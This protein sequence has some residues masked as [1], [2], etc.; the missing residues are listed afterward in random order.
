MDQ[1]IQVQIQCLTWFFLL[2]FG[3][4]RTVDHSCGAAK[5]LITCLMLITAFLHIWSKGHCEPRNKVGSLSTTKHLVR[6]ELRTSWC[7]LQHLNPLG[8]FP[9]PSDHNHTEL[10]FLEKE[11]D[12]WTIFDNYLKF[13]RHII[14]QLNKA[15]QLMELITSCIYFIK[16]SFPFFINALARPH[17]EYCVSICSQFLNRMRSWLKM[18]FVVHRN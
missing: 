5:L 4:P 10:E 3:C 12:L 9:T 15:N 17:L 11:K 8:H 6:F 14:T 7:W 1:L 16:N 2:L 18:Y 13:S